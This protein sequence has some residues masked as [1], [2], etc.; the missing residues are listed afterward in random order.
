MLLAQPFKALPLGFQL[1]HSH[2]ILISHPQRQNPRHLFRDQQIFLPLVP[3]PFSLVPR[4][5]SRVPFIN[6]LHAVKVAS[7]VAGV[8]VVAKPTGSVAQSHRKFVVNTDG[9]HP[10]LNFCGEFRF[11]QKCPF[12]RCHIV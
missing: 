9:F 4:P 2:R 10:T 11:R 1:R 5:P 7:K 8:L 12:L 3:L 6:V